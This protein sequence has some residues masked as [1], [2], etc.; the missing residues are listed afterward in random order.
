MKDKNQKFIKIY[1]LQIENE[2]FC[3]CEMASAV[4]IK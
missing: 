1:L 2:L 3:V 4:F